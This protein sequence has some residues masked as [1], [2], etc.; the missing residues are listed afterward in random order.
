MA[1][2]TDEERAA[3]LDEDDKTPEQIAEDAKAAEAALKAKDDETD[4]DPA[5]DAA[6][7]AA[8]AA[9]AAKADP[10]ETDKLEAPFAAR[11]S[12]P[13]VSDHDAK[14]SALL[15]ERKD[16]RAKYRAGELTAEEFDA[17]SDEMETT[18][19]G[20]REDRIKSDMAVKHNEDVEV[21]K[22]LWTVDQFKANVKE[23]QGID[24]NAN[25]ALLNMWDAEVKALSKDDANST[26]SYEWFLREGHKRVIDSLKKLAPSLGL[27]P[28]E[29]EGSTAEARADAV[30]TAL[31]TRAPDTKGAKSLAGLPTASSDVP[32]SGGEFAHLDKLDGDDLEIAVAKMTREQQDRWANS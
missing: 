16:L 30:R 25:P 27:V 13:D 20:L 1:E 23:T 29:G 24:Y 5:A 14:I 8:A 18:I 4:D 2:M 32:G 12:S 3:L 21:Q 9:A 7:A 11:L 17:K 28:K 19:Q 15:D 31:R 22:Y 26:R 6:E 10:V